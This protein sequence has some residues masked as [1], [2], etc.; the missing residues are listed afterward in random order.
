MQGMDV[1]YIKPTDEDLQG[2]MNQ[3]TLW[4]DEQINELL[5]KPLTSEVYK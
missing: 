1:Y 4:L 5:T 2:A 3:Y